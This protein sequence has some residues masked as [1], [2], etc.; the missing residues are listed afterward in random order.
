MPK[1][2]SIANSKLKKVIPKRLGQIQIKYVL[3][4]RILRLGP[5]DA[6]YTHGQIGKGS[7]GRREQTSNLQEQNL[8]Q[9]IKKQHS[10]NKMQVQNSVRANRAFIL[11]RKNPEK[12]YSRI[13]NLSS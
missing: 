11:T 7:T 13:R 8:R 5:I 4:T 2:C 12:K 3:K 10:T 1:R 6:A 9:K